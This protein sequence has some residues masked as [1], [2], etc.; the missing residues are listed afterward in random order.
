MHL[1]CAISGRTRPF[2]IRLREG[3][4]ALDLSSKDEQTFLESSEPVV[5]RAA[6]SP[7]RRSLLEPLFV[8]DEVVKKLQH[9]RIEVQQMV[10]VLML[11]NEEFTDL[12]YQSARHMT[13]SSKVPIEF[14]LRAGTLTIPSTF[15]TVQTF[16]LDV[17]NLQKQQ[18]QLG[19]QGRFS[20]KHSDILK[21]ALRTY[22]RSLMQNH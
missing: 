19:A 12:V 17:D 10:G 22:L 13:A 5:K 14:D 18:L 15:G 6:S 21:A 1:L 9:E 4:S 8:F 20:V 7:T 3:V 2:L 11:T 16:E